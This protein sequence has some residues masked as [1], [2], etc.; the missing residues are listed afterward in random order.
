MGGTTLD[1]PPPPPLCW[2]QQTCQGTG[3]KAGEK[4]RESWDQ[5]SR[6][7]ESSMWQLGDEQDRL[8]LQPLMFYFCSWQDNLLIILSEVAICTTKLLQNTKLKIKFTGFSIVHLQS[9]HQLAEHLSSFFVLSQCNAKSFPLQNS[10]MSH[11]VWHVLM[12]C[13]VMLHSL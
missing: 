11:S 12:C 7:R 1:S 10:H 4:A 9:S 13:S 2:I 6:K 3:Q 8:C 5:R